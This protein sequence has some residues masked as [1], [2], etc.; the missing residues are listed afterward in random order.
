MPTLLVWGKRDAII[1]FEHGLLAHAAMPGS[2][3]IAFDDAGHFPHHSDPARFNAVLREF[4]ASTEPLAPCLQ[5]GLPTEPSPSRAAG[6]LPWHCFRNWTTAIPDF[7]VWGSEAQT[8]APTESVR[9]NWI[10]PVPGNGSTR[11][12]SCL[13]ISEVLGIQEETYSTVPDT[14]MSAF[15]SS[16]IR[17][18]V[19]GQAFSSGPNL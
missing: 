16:R 2:R 19:R 11:P 5:A 1:P 6:P 7:K 3:L 8:T 10:I 15:R 4:L 9:A 17:R 18:F 14:R 12:L 13:R